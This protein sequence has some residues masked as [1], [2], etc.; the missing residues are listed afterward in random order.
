MIRRGGS[1]TKRPVIYRRCQFGHLV[2]VNEDDDQIDITLCA[3]CMK[4][5]IRLRAILGDPVPPEMIEL[6]ASAARRR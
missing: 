4:R 5:S 1:S 6:A 3:I 2:R